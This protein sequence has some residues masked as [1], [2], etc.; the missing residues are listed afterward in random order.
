MNYVPTMPRQHSG[1]DSLVTAAEIAERW[2]VHRDTVYRIPEG[3]RIKGIIGA[4]RPLPV[5]ISS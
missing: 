3:A 1:R 5:P 4:W 2:Q